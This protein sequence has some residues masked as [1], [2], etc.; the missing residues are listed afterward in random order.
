MVAKYNKIY[1]I[2][3]FTPRYV[4]PKKGIIWLVLNILIYCNVFFEVSWKMHS[5]KGHSYRL[6]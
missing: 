6:T 3:K 1:K 5:Y 2:Y 4:F